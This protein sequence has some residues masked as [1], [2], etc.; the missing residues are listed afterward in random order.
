MA[1]IVRRSWRSGGRRRYLSP[2]NY[3]RDDL[4][5]PILVHGNRVEMTSFSRP[6][7]R[8]KQDERSTFG[9]AL[10]AQLLSASSPLR[11]VSRQGVPR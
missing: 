1:R 8:T 6:I 9:L 11:A 3:L 10:S 4:G 5:A 2:P 7:I